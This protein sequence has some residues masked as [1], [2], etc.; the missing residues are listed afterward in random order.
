MNEPPLT[1]H[2]QYILANTAS[3]PSWGKISDIFGRKSLLLVSCFIFFVG[4]LLCAVVNDLQAFI[5]ARA[6]QG[7]GSGGMHTIVNICISDLFSQR[8]RGM[9]YGLM[10]VVWALASAIGPVIGGV[11]TTKAE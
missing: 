11:F 5:A 10:S 2:L 6:V 9:W 4:S 8:D 7:L 3:V 1:H